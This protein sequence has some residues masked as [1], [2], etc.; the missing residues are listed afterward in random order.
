LSK[1]LLFFEILDLLIKQIEIRFKD[2]SSLNFL[3]LIDSNKFDVFSRN[4]PEKQLNSLIN[5]YRGFF[6]NERLKREL[7]VLYSDKLIFGNSPTVRE[8]IEFIHKNDII[9][10]VLEIYKLFCLIVS[11]PP[12]SASIERSFS[13]LK[14]VKSYS[15]NTMSQSRLNNLSVLAI[16]RGLVKELIKDENF[17]TKILD[18]FETTKSRKIDLIYKYE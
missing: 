18:D 12:T 6:N 2:I 5:N 13:A 4:F 17:Y 14:R 8:M 7:Q 1:K 9:T 3:E 15:R 10:E 11:L 16:E